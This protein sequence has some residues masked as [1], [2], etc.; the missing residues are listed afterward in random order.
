MNL[1][2][3][4]TCQQLKEGIKTTTDDRRTSH[5]SGSDLALCQ[6]AVN[7]LGNGVGL[8]LETDVAETGRHQTQ[9]FQPPASHRKEK[10][11]QKAGGGRRTQGGAASW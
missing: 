7:G 2:G 1:A 4:Q 8:T 5:V 9:K 3:E 6:N 11:N 10:E